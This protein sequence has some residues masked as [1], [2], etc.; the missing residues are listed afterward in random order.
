MA[1]S[2]STDGKS[3]LAESESCAPRAVLVTGAAGNIGLWFAE[4]CCRRYRLRLL[5]RH[6]NR[7]R[8]RSWRSGAKSFRATWEISSA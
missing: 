5:V 7:S 4:H 8:P 6:R 3:A 1:E 2:F